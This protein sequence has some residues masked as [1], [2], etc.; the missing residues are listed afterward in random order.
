MKLVAVAT[1]ISV[2]AALC[3]GVARCDLLVD[4]VICRH[5]TRAELEA[6]RQRTIVITAET[7]CDQGCN[8]Y[9]EARE[10]G[11]VVRPAG[12]VS[13][14]DGRHGPYSLISAEG[15]DLIGVVETSEE[16]PKLLIIHDF[17]AGRTDRD[18]PTGEASYEEGLRFHDELYARLRSENP[19][20]PAER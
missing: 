17:A 11:R 18:L 20:L 5:T 2:A 19:Q 1:R 12:Y 10:S 6:G 3:L 8:V 14:D 13:S 4:E 15:G 16:R 9:Y 7:C